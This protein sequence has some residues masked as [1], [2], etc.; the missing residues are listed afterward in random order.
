MNISSGGIDL[1][2]SDVVLQGADTL[3][4]ELLKPLDSHKLSTT[5]A[6]GRFRASAHVIAKVDSGRKYTGNVSLLVTSRPFLTDFLRLQ[7]IFL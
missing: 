7:P 4:L 3:F 2:I 5:F 1:Q 6:V